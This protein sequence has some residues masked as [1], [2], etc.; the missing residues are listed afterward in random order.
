MRLEEKLQAE[1]DKETVEES[2][3][4]VTDEELKPGERQVISDGSEGPVVEIIKRTT[5]ERS[6]Y[7]EI[8]KTPVG[9]KEEAGEL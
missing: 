5:P 2:R 6:D 4:V 7:P 8:D 9:S 1:V 3:I